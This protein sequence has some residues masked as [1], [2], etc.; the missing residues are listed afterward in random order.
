MECACLSS[1]YRGVRNM[2]ASPAF[3][4]YGE[5]LGS[6]GVATVT[7]GS[8]ELESTNRHHADPFLATSLAASDERQTGASLCPHTSQDSQCS[9][10]L[11][12]LGRLCQSHPTA[13]GESVQTGPFGGFSGEKH[14]P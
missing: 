3:M 13:V 4:D 11:A 8:G 7:T 9:H 14:P 2:A 10:K 12:S 1:S 6:A 5:H